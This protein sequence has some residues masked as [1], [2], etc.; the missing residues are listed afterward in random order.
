MVAASLALLGVLIV[1]VGAAWVAAGRDP[2]CIAPGCT[3]SACFAAED[4]GPGGHCPLH[5]EVGL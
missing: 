4:G 5:A 1:G 3:R 2:R